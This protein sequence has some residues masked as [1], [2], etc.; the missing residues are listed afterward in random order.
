MN[1]HE[2][3]PLTRRGALGGL[4]AAGVGLPLLAACSG[5]DGGS[6][7][8]DPVTSSADPTPSG[9]GSGSPEAGSSSSAAESEAGTGDGAAEVLVPLADVA[10]GGGVVLADA[11]VVVTQP[12][13]GEV[14]A[15]TTTC[16]HQGCPVTEVT[17]GAIVCP[18][19]RSLFSIED[20]APTAGPAASPLEAVAVAV[21]QGS[22]VR[23]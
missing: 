2:R 8:T 6:V 23:A 14:R 18:C 16:T 11:G 4:A 13:A 1:P 10:V 5:D 20:G 17:D 7:A 12:T 15:F 21:S 9:A 19:H 3:R 22:V